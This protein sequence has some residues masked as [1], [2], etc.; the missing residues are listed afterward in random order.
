MVAGLYTA[1]NRSCGESGSD[2]G[3]AA[4]KYIMPSTDKALMQGMKALTDLIQSGNYGAYARSQSRVAKEGV[5]DG[6]R[7]IGRHGCDSAQSQ[8]FRRNLHGLILFRYRHQPGRYDESLFAALVSEQAR[9]RYGYPDPT[10]PSKRWRSKSGADVTSMANTKRRRPRQTAKIQEIRENCN[11]IMLRS[12]GVCDAAAK[13]GPYFIYFHPQHR[14]GKYRYSNVYTVSRTAPDAKV[15]FI[16]ESWSFHKRRGTLSKGKTISRGKKIART[17]VKPLIYPQAFG[18][19]YG[20]RQNICAPY[21]AGELSCSPN[22][23]YCRER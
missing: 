17:A 23:T 13:C 22:R 14:K 12:K 8:R 4:I 16:Q 20:G 18:D 7:L 21:R 11:N 10:K 2:V 3:F 5:D 19:Y 6:N 15:Q 9:R 1:F